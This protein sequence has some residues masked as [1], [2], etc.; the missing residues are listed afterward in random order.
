M[1]NMY[2]HLRSL[3][4]RV[5]VA[6][7]MPARISSTAALLFVA[8]LCQHG[9]VQAAHNAAPPSFNQ[10]SVNITSG[11][12]TI[13]NLV[14]AG[15]ISGTPPFKIIAV[16]PVDGANVTVV[17]DVCLDI[18]I[19]GSIPSP[20]IQITVSNLHGQEQGTISTNF[21]EFENNDLL[22]SSVGEAPVP[23][24]SAIQATDTNG[25]GAETVTLDGSQSHDDNGISK[26]RWVAI[27][28]VEIGQGETTTATF[29]VGTHTLILEVTDLEGNVV[30]TNSTVTIAA[31]PPS[32]A[33]VANAGVDQ[34]IETRIEGTATVQ[35]D[36]SAS[37]DDVG[38]VS[39][40][41]FTIEDGF[42]NDLA[43]IAQP[44]INLPIGTHQ[45]FLEV[46]DAGSQLARDD[47]IIT[48]AASTPG[49]GVTPPTS[50]QDVNTLPG[51]DENQRSTAVSIDALCP[52][53]A[54]ISGTLTPG[55]AE[56]DLLDRCTQLKNTSTTL[57]QAQAGLAAMAGE[58]VAAQRSN[59]IELSGAQYSNLGARINALKRGATG[60]NVTNLNL[61]IDGQRVSG[62]VLAAGLKALTGSGASGD[63]GLGLSERLG[64]FVN[65]TVGFGEQDATQREAGFDFDTRG[66]TAGIDYRFTDNL[67]LGMATGYGK[68]EVDFNASAGNLDSDGYSLSM[69]GTYYISGQYYL[70]GIVSY[71]SNDYDSTRNIVYTDASGT[72]SRT[73]L[74]N[75]EGNQLFVGLS[76]G[77]DWQQGGWRIGPN[78]SLYYL[79]VSIDAYREN[80][81]SGLDLAFDEQQSDS[82]TLTLG[83][84][85][86]YSYSMAWGVLIPSARLH[87]VHEFENSSEIIGARFANDPF[88]N[89]PTNPT[90]ALQVTT[91]NPD[92]NYFKFGVG[93][94]GQ[95]AHGLSAFID[96][97]NIVAFE[98]LTA[99]EFTFGV[100]YAANF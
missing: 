100:R 11:S 69:Y 6:C 40:R 97:Q 85:V 92:R 67:V 78:A 99:H 29:K 75:T 13:K 55:S 71:G 14:D 53:L 52:R 4:R 66:I 26:Y 74:G 17:G 38:I 34:N 64:F 8:G 27:D 9:A 45:I 89:D 88:F 79:D 16:T 28:N 62:N 23:V 77:W 72:V 46:S 31:A 76:T 60:L 98:N 39:Y 32:S 1:K 22:C 70:D 94:S 5:V 15:I 80:G 68:S 24:L 87:M 61:N 54:A 19:T 96:Y 21:V 82:F 25:D 20:Q 95:F 49:P 91:D 93:L 36:G 81:A 65:G 12:N 35:L 2:S 47:V 51:L 58:E 3:G 48:I 43:T 86:S 84:D 56:A 63:D 30:Q 73:A 33:P 37:S 18:S 10:G 57:A 42:E 50:T 90:P 41:W 7:A 83:G 59:A 44:I